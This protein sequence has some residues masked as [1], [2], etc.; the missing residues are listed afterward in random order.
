MFEHLAKITEESYKVFVER[1][2]LEVLNN[3]ND[4]MGVL[5]ESNKYLAQAIH[6]GAVTVAEYFTG[7]TKEMVVAD[8]VAAQLAVLRLIDRALEAQSL[9]VELLKKNRLAI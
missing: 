8:A 4:Y 7:E 6:A 3:I 1:E 5:K 2:L 9:E